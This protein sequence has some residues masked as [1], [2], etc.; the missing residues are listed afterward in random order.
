VIYRKQLK[1]AITNVQKILGH[2]ENQ[3]RSDA[4]QTL[5]DRLANVLSVVEDSGL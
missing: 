5:E 4:Q 2:F 1:T 3:F